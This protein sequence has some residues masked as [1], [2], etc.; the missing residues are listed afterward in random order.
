MKQEV[1]FACGIVD[2]TCEDWEAPLPALFTECHEVMNPS[3]KR[4]AAVGCAYQNLWPRSCAACFIETLL[5][6]RYYSHLSEPR[7]RE[8]L[9]T[10]SHFHRNATM[11]NAASSV[12]REIV[13]LRR[14]LRAM[15][16]LAPSPRPEAP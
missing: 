3:T 10:G 16:P 7:R 11:P 13:I 14:S 5:A 1:L 8:P 2:P 9:C 15:G 4:F 12:T 6:P